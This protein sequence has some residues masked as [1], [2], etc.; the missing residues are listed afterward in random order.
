[1][2]L[3]LAFLTVTLALCA[4]AADVTGSWKAVFIGPMGNRPKMVSK[5]VFDL[6]ADGKT[7][8]GMARAGYW[9]GDAPIEDGKIDGDRFS[10]TVI[11]K[12]PW[13]SGGP[14][15]TASG[16]PRLKF[17]G[18]I[19]GNEMKL[20]L[21]WDSVMIYGNVN[22]DGGTVFEMEGKKIPD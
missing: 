9:P 11:G 20:S 14:Q 3:R 21:I 4:S 16:Y 6:K 19:S 17:T 2:K 18:T 1:M 12:S 13:Q 7:L 10:F 5:I 15:G 22:A 8:T